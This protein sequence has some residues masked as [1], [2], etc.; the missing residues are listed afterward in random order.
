MAA[1]HDHAQLPT[2]GG[3][4]LVAWQLKNKRVLIVGGGEVASGRL[5]S[6]LGTDVAAVIV[7][8][9]AV[10]LHPTTQWLIDNSDRIIYHDRPFQG[11]EDLENIDM[12]L[13]AIDDVEESRRIC[14]M[15]RSARIP[16]NVADIPPSCDFYF[17]SQIRRGPLQI[18]I[19]TNGQGPKLANRIKQHIEGGLPP[20]VENAIN[21]VGVLRAK[22]REIA[23]GVG[24]DVSKKRM[25]WMSEICATWDLNS[26]GA[27]NETDID[28]LISEGWLKEK[29]PLQDDYLSQEKNDSSVWGWLFRYS[30]T[31]TVGFLTGVALVYLSHSL[32][33]H[34]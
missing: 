17:G 10:G 21:K 25:K 13:T 12:V 24:G 9:P 20:G 32:R 30:L 33:S 23:P 15:C 19:S 18:M 6:I 16:V 4:L 27:L 28:K 1:A 34:R 3:S 31:T 22:L 26:L 2:G 5:E 8:S 29:I 14:Q 11:P 7:V